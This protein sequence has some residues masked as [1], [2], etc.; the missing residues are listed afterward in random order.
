MPLSLEDVEFTARKA[1]FDDAD[2]RNMVQQHAS[3][4]ESTGRKTAERRGV[5]EPKLVS[6]GG[7]DPTEA[8]LSARKAHEEK[9]PVLILTGANQIGKTFA[10]KWLGNKIGDATL[11]IAP[12]TSHFLDDSNYKNAEYWEHLKVPRALIID[13]L[14][15]ERF[16]RPEYRSKF[17]SNLFVLINSRLET[18]EK[19]TILTTNLSVE[20]FKSEYCSGHNAALYFRLKAFMSAV[21]GVAYLRGARGDTGNESRNGVGNDTD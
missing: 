17:H 3:Y 12:E 11:V 18:A 19:V 6:S 7:L 4:L 10:A 2:I 15:R 20:A 1:G 16:T 21:D 9:W 5:Y 8:L 14:G 13:D